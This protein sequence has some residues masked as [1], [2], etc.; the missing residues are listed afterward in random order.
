MLQIQDSETAQLTYDQQDTSSVS[1]IAKHPALDL[2]FRSYFLLAVTCSMFSLGIWAAY[3]NGYFTFSDN[4][5]SPL[6]W[7]IHEMIFGFAATVAVGFVLTAAQTWTG[8]PSIKGLPV[9]AFIA[10]WLMVRVALFINLPSTIV[11]A[12]ILQSFWWL[13]AIAVFTRLVLKSNNRR[14]YLFIPLLSVLMLLNI[15]LLLLDFNGHY[16]LTRHIA[17]TCVLMFCLLMGI[18]GGRV[19]PFFTIS[20]AKLSPITSPSW[21]T[22]LLTITSVSGVLV[23]FSSAFIDLPFSPAGLMITAGLLH[24]VRQSYWRSFATRNI[25]LLWSLHLSYFSLGLGLILLGMSYQPL[26]GIGFIQLGISFG[27][28]L[29]LIT[30]AAMGLMIFAMMS[31]VSLGHTGR[32]LTPSKLVSWVF[33]LIILSALTRAF[34]PTLIF[35]PLLSWNISAFAWLIAGALFLKIYYPILT[36]KRIEKSFSR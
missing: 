4:G 29:H 30:I 5:I 3:F 8:Q 28:A 1:F 16:E 31:R 15:A 12:I 17:R 7:H 20:G 11:I 14:N 26:H 6:A 9:L 2:P 33:I 25:A 23:F 10:L 21:L 35:Q 32:A 27:D 36:A 13:G 24:L 19:I 22:P 18:L 34:M